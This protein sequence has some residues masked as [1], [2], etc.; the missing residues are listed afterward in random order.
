MSEK[1]VKNAKQIQTQDKR[2]DLFD[3][4]MINN[5]MKAL[6]P[7]QKKEYEEIGKYMFKTD[8]AKTALKDKTIDPE[9][10]LNDLVNYSLNAIK[11]GL[12][13]S[14]LSEKELRI[15]F[16]IKG[17]KWY[18]EFGFTFEEIP[19]IIRFGPI[20]PNQNS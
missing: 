18:E 20:N 19:P 11:S 9:K 5:A 10:E 13:P 7:E 6:T 8:Y 3:N 2:I 16:E 12:H 17:D 15:L 1:K 4:P 14:D